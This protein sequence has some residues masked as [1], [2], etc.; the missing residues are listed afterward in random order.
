MIGLGSDKN[1]LD[2][3]RERQRWQHERLADAANNPKNEDGDDVEEH[4]EQGEDEH[5]ARF[6][7]A[8]PQDT[9]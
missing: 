8:S 5:Q 4:K 9:Q 6:L 1:T 2:S 7:Q 3:H